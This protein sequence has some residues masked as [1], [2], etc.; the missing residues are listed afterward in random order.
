M[1]LYSTWLGTTLALVAFV[2][3]GASGQAALLDDFADGIDPQWFPLDSNYEL[4][5]AGMPIG[6]K[7]WGPGIFDASSGVLNLRTTGSVPP[8]PALPP[9]PE[10]FDPLD[11]GTLG[12]VW[13][14][15]VPD[16]TFSSGRLRATV[17]A[18]GPS[19]VI[20]VLRGDP[21]TFTSYSFFGSGSYGLFGFSRSDIG[22]ILGRLELVPGLSFTR[23]ED[24]M[25]EFGVVGDEFSMK[26]WKV[27]DPEPLAPQLTVVDSTYAAGGLG[28]FANLYTNNIPAPTP[29][30]ATFDNVFFTPI[31]LVP[32]LPS[33]IKVVSP[34]QYANREADAR[35]NFTQPVRY[36]QVFPASDFAML[37]GP[38]EITEIAWR[39]D[40]GGAP[41]EVTTEHVELSLSVTSRG[42]G[43]LSTLFQQNVE[44]N[45]VVVFDGGST[46]TSGN[47]GPPGGPKE[48]DMAI[49]LQTPFVYD[50]RDGNLLMEFVSRSGW[51]VAPQNDG[52]NSPSVSIIA[53]GNP[54]AVSGIR[55]GGIV[56]QLTLVPI[57]D[58]KAQL[59]AGDADQDLD[60]DQ[61]DLIRV[62]QA[63]RYLTGQAATWGQGD[64]NGAPG[65]SQGSPP[66]GNGF[67]DQLDIVAALAP[68]HYL[69]GPFAAIA[70]KGNPN[71]E[72]TSIIY[73]PSTGELGVNAPVSTQLTSINID[74]AGGIFTGARAQNL[75]GSFDN[76]AD[77]NI[78]KATF[79]SSFGSLSFGNVA[80]TG[81]SEQ[82]VLNDLT[83]VGSLAGGGAL[84]NVD[85]VYVPEPSAIVLVWLG[86]AWLAAWR[87]KRRFA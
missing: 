20:L 27:G 61:F 56:T 17:R 68:A 43:N 22:G 83:V 26:A 28:V 45:P 52:F 41:P 11:S 66:P 86:L 53:P 76:D 54:D 39:P 34:S 15:S 79:G 12:L 40:A 74:S 78:F 50:P 58:V 16:P 44:S 9:G 37:D 31:T 55:F 73:N 38:H 23:G 59:Q 4:D 33:P 32:E 65:G 3:A 35:N 84:G 47:V 13:G 60:F 46:F 62:Q 8:N 81:L 75:G 64:W 67:F 7:P 18:N 19:D 14:P 29:V 36:Q 70:G 5:P 71:D 48:F 72:Q 80:Q 1:R 57:A 49:T 30:D 87:R 42:P 6:P 69:K 24:W 51:D 85:L 21:A 77:N 2:T 25:M 10:V 63:A 82:F